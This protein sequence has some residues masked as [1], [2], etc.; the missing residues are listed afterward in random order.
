MPSQP[1]SVIKSQYVIVAGE[2]YCRSLTIDKTLA[3][4]SVLIYARLRIHTKTLYKGEHASKEW[5][6][7]RPE[8]VVLRKQYLTIQGLFFLGTGTLLR[9]CTGLR[10]VRLASQ[11]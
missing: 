5:L 4:E 3:C 11:T 2:Q 10:D 8:E 7:R 9:A 6:M 1:I